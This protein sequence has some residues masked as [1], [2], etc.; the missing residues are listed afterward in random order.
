MKRA[1][2]FRQ[3]FSGFVRAVP[4]ARTPDDEDMMS[5]DLIRRADWVVGRLN[6]VIAEVEQ[7]L[8]DCVQFVRIN[9]HGR[10]RGPSLIRCDAYQ[11]VATT[12]VVD[13]VGEGADGVQDGLRIPPFLEFQPLPFDEAT[14]E[15]FIEIY[16]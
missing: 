15:N 3:G 12:E 2:V 14:S 6:S 4:A 1:I 16:W 10:E 13:I 5:I 8:L 9:S 11:N 7:L